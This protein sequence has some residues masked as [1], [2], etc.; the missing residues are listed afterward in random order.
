MF[1]SRHSDQFPSPFP[2]D[3]RVAVNPPGESPTTSS[4]ASLQ[5]DLERDRDRDQPAC[6]AVQDE[7]QR[8]LSR[9]GTMRRPIPMSRVGRSAATKA[10]HTF[11][12]LLQ[13]LCEH[14][15]NNPSLATL[16]PV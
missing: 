3:E 14:G 11:S 10:V 2:I 9:N 16:P 6:L 1:E 7:C 15:S 13:F 8:E 5:P 12:E 4:P